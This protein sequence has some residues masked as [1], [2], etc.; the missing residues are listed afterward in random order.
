M[1]TDS[2][3]KNSIRNSSI[4][5]ITQVLTII[6][7]FVVKT[8]FI[9]ILGKEYLG[10]NGLFS[11]IITLLSLADLGIGVAI[12]YSLY[13]PLA[14]KDTKKIRVLM[15]FY[16]NVY[17]IIGCVVLV[18][19]LSLTPFLSHIIKDMP[20]IKGIY[21]IYDLFVIHSALT[22]FFVYKKFLIDSDQKG[23]ITSNITFISS[24]FLNITRV[25]LLILT[26]NF[27]IYLFCSIVFVLIQ[28]IW[29]S[30]KADKMYP[31]IKDKTEDVI[32]KEDKDEIITNVKALLIYKIGSVVTLGTDNIVISKFMGL[33]PVGIYSNYILITNSLNNVLNQLFNS[34]TSSIGNL[35]ATNNE[36]SKSIYENLSFFNFYIY[37][38]FSVCLFI[39]INPFIE[40]WLNHDYV[41]S[42]TVAFLLAFNFYLTGMGAVTNSFRSA[43]GL[44]YKAKFRPIVMVIINIVV[45]V[46]LVK[47][48]GIAGVLIGTIV[49]RLLTIAW[50]D[51]LVIYKYGFKANV[52]EYYRRYIYYLIIFL[53]S[54]GILYYLS[55]F[56]NT[57]H[58]L[59]WLFTAIITFIL[60]NLIIILLFRR[61]EEFKY[62]YEKISNIFKKLFR[63]GM[64]I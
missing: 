19:G 39:L 50:L 5:I 15:K 35:V 1:N 28:N 29:I 18:I 32:S 57:T 62:F 23:Y 13:K 37:S 26:K 12:P 59:I 21:F 64:K 14:D 20:N 4:S 58:I 6:M 16:R 10:I 48:M 46:I 22:Y 11:N 55:T 30:I 41:L 52:F 44:F 2:R 42:T 9:F 38:L 63:K 7:D 8:I 17:N 3:T 61:T 25:I 40:I 27:I 49:S 60:Y 34:I 31:F 47:P 45:S 24:F 51:P 43:Y 36:R 33:I 56:F 53:S 54:C